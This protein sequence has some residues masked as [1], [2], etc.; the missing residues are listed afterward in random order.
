L[1]QK[2]ETFEAKEL[3]IIVERKSNV[4]NIMNILLFAG[5]L[6]K[7]S[8]NKKLIGVA[9]KILQKKEG[10]KTTLID[11]QLLNFPVYDGDIELVGIPENVLKLGALIANSDAIIISSPEYNGSI[12]SPLKTA[13]DWVSRVKPIP[14]SKKQIL[15]LGASPG[16]LGAIRGLIHARIP[17]EALGN[18][19]FPQS[20]GLPK[21][22]TAFDENNDLVDAARMDRLAKLIASFTEHCQKYN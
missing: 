2:S 10:I 6:R 11:L 5:S 8:L 20:Y 9:D 16:E 3:R 17:F 21:A 19:V 7:A 4:E 22:D 14:L 1:R 18:F 15:L 13:I 12:S